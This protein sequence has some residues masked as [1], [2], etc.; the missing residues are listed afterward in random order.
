MDKKDVVLIGLYATNGKKLTPVQVQKLFFLID[1]NLE[2]FID[3]RK[4]DFQPYNYGPFDRE[5]YVELEKL[6]REGM[7]YIDKSGRW[8]TYQISG[9]GKEHIK[10]QFENLPKNVKD[11][12]IEL[13][14]FV[15]EL[16]FSQLV[17]S[18]YKAYPEMRAN[19]VFQD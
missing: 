12:L 4:F 6:S 7:V 11:Y 9:E 18:I 15:T 13:G 19:S 17:S 14:K 2:K 16:T 1:N 3:G 8:P 10:S 5:V